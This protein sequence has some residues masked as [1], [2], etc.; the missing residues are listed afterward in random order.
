MPVKDRLRVGCLTMG[1]TT[2]PRRMRH[3]PPESP[4]PMTVGTS[5][6]GVDNQASMGSGLPLRKETP[7]PKD[8]ARG[9]STTRGLGRMATVRDAANEKPQGRRTLYWAIS[10]SE[11]EVDA[12]E[13][14]D[15]GGEGT[16]V[17][18]VGWGSEPTERKDFC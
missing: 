9:S 11:D 5:G 1:P 15:A 7:E 2:S 8:E 18:E 17:L 14:G 3:W 4:Q 13:V 6:P 12:G 16:I 10:Q